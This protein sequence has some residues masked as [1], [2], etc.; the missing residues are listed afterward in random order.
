[1]SLGCSL[2]LRHFLGLVI[3]VD[4][5]LDDAHVGVRLEAVKRTKPRAAGATSAVHTPYSSNL[6][7]G[8]WTEA[9]LLMVPDYYNRVNADL[10]RIMPPDAGIVLE[11][12]CGTGALAEAYRRINYRVTYCGIEKNIEA[13]RIAGVNGRIDRLFVG[14]LEAVDPVALGLSEE[15][16]SV[17]CLVFGDVL[18]HLVDPWIVMAR[19]A[20]LV[21]AGGQIL[22]CIPNV[23]HYSVIVNLMRGNWDYQ[24]E[25]LLD[26]THLRF[27]TL[28]GVRDLF[29]KAGLRIFD[30]QPRWWPGNEPDRFQQVM[31]PVLSSLGIELESFALQTRTVQYLVRAARLDESPSQMLIWTLVGS[32]L[33]SESRVKEPLEFLATI[34]GVRTRTG[35][36]LQYDELKQAWPGE[37]RIF[38]QQRVIIPLIDH[39]NLQRQLIDNGYLIVAE[40]DDDPWHFGELASTD[41]LAL[42]S[43]HCVQTTTERMAETIRE[44]NPFVA[45]FPNHIAKLPR[46]RLRAKDD[47]ATSPIR[48]FFGALNREKDWAADMPVVNDVL[49]R[50]GSKVHVQVVYDRAFFDALNTPYKFFEPLCPIERYHE[51]LAEA[52]IA[53]LPLT[54]T[55]FNEHKSDL[56]FIEC[57]AHGVVSLA[58]PT[59]Y[60][61]SIADGETGLIYQSPDELKD[62]LER[63]LSDSS[64]RQRLGENARRYV[65][66]NRMLSRH[67]R[68]RHAWYLSMIAQKVVLEA[69]LRKRAPEVFQ[70]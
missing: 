36:G 53:L 54:P 14:D 41:F 16:P 21:R 55:R 34:T 59:V 23:Q 28:S 15:Q 3:L 4:A 31:A 18:E 30:I 48:L 27:F 8:N 49:T 60:G 38:I 67:F 35:T 2:A 56:K 7:T 62:Q 50:Y 68:A 17:E 69:E 61:G 32:A 39:L 12:G 52:D 26:R 9:N 6:T 40:I 22:A 64:L 43:C 24:D 57:A 33:G 1:V 37:Q 65:A 11:A 25:G 47:L 44:F 46:L 58:S 51:L 5:V 66:E 20:R 10:L 29:S 45:T 42:R 19:L 13:A 63:L 70:N